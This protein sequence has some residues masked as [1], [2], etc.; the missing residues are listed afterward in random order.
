M[1]QNMTNMTVKKMTLNGV[2][3]AVYAVLTLINPLSFGAVQFRVSTLL[4]PLAVFV[5]QVRAGL[6]LGTAIGNLNSSLG[7]IDIVVGSVVSAIAVY[8]VPKAKAK[9]IMPVLYAIDSGVLVALE[10][11]YCFK[12]PIWYNVLTVGISGVI[13]YTIGLVVMKQ[14]AKPLNRYFI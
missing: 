5:P 9:A 7:I 3:A 13:L 14:V 2:I 1:K 8:A 6:V 10:L 4:L 11:W 12:T